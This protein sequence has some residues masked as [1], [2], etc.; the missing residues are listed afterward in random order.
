MA[1]VGLNYHIEEYFDATHNTESLETKFLTQL[2]MFNFSDLC[3]FTKVTRYPTLS[4]NGFLFGLYPYLQ[5]RF[6]I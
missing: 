4:E 6:T 3:V 2:E 5:I 1:G